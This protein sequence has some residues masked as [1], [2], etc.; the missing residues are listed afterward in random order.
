[1]FFI[2][3]IALAL[4]TFPGVIVHELAHQLFCRW[5]KVPVFNV[6]YFQ[7]K[8]PVGYVHHEK[9]KSRLQMVMISIGPFFIN[10]IVGA[11]IALPAAMPVFALD[12]AGPLD[13]FLIYLGVS[14]AMHAFP[15]RGDAA[16]VLEIAK[17]KET[18]RWLRILSYPIVGMI[19]L[20]SLGSMFWLDILYGIGV[21]V[22]IPKLI[23]SLMA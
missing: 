3:G 13:Y 9:P 10:T 21:A 1:M 20:C 6:V 19:Y 16:N 18:P 12:N 11:L 2:R 15:S 8:S 22:G 5:Y 4:L 7:L 23:V 17:S 14:I